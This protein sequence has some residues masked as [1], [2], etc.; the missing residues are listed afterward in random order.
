MAFVT[1]CTIAV[2]RYACLF[3]D[4]IVHRDDVT[5]AAAAR[6]LDDHMYIVTHTHTH[7]Q[8]DKDSEE[9]FFSS[10]AVLYRRHT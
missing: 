6:R 1:V 3:L 5:P 10:F 4:H 8:R 7:T 2:Y 9:Q